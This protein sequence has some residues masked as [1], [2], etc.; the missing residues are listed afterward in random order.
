M[1]EFTMHSSPEFH[2]QV[3]KDS[4]LREHNSTVTKSDLHKDIV[5]AKYDEIRGEE[6]EQI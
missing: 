5:L 2:A 6:I 4:M 3:L 1:N